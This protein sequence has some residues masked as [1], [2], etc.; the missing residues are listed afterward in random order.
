MSIPE[1][2]AWR[3]TYVNTAIPTTQA[4]GTPTSTAVNINGGNNTVSVISSNYVL[5]SSNSSF[6][7][8]SVTPGDTVHVTAASNVSLI[9]T[10]EVLEVISNQQIALNTSI[11]ATGVSF[12]VTRTLTKAQQAEAVAAI[13][14]DFNDSRVIH[15]QPDTVGIVVDGVTTYLPGYYLC[16]AL[17][18]M[19][20]GF[21]VQQG[22]TNIGV[23]GVSDLQ[24]SNFYFSK[25]NLNTMA[26]AG[27]FLLVQ[28]TQGG[29][30]YV[31]HELTTDMSAL[32]YREVLI[33]KNWDFLSYTYHDEM[34]PFI[35]VWNITPDTLNTARQTLN[36]KTEL[37]K[38]QKLPKIGPPLINGV[39]QSLA[40]DTVNRDRV[41][42]SMAITI[43]YPW[44]Y[45]DLYLII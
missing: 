22:F 33:R 36:A 30:P 40:Q 11:V 45:L 10:W 35:G 14:S 6:I 9:G 20:S 4:I 31:R 41:A 29:I 43:V 26:A 15:V 44:N 3:I 25:T 8:D 1:S 38:S 2:A 16:C 18:G 42:C 5:T 12:Y 23:A 28:S 32:E 34:A 21:P 19:T 17:G 7:T 37:L 27:T 24:N 39:I 13:S